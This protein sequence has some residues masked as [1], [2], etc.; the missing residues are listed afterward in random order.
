MT[1]S[2]RGDAPAVELWA[3]RLVTALLLSVS[4]FFVRDAWAEIRA[5][6]VELTRYELESGQRITAVETRLN[7]PGPRAP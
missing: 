7:I 1:P 3:L 4:A 5:M 6:R 2:P